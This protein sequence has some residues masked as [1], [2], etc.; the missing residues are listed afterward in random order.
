[1]NSS[2]VRAALDL[3]DAEPSKEFLSALR[4]R[5]LAE[6]SAAEVTTTIQPPS[7]A[8]SETAE[9]YVML[10]PNPN[11]RH[12]SRRV[13]IIVLAAA[14]CAVAAAAIVINNRPNNDSGTSGGLR[15]VDAK[16]ALSLGQAALITADMLNGGAATG[17]ARW[18]RV[19]DLTVSDYAEQSA[20]TSASLPGC[21]QLASVGLM[22]P[23]TKSVT[24]HQDF[25]NGPVPM[26]HD[27]WVFARP[28]DASRAMDVIAGNVYPTCWF[29]LFDRLTPLG[30]L[31][32]TTSISHATDMDVSIAQHGDRQIIITQRITYTTFQSGGNAVAI[33]AYV[34]VGRAIVFIDPQYLGDVGPNSN[35]EQAIAASTEALQKVFGP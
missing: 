31:S 26:L 8:A 16:E 14:A 19:D 34:Q 28:E 30:R 35:V 11:R 17:T 21:A 24:V 10:A 15:D 25:V 22:Q 3:V 29:D 20:A 1:V 7:A 27:V 18:A 5:L 32:H 4:S 6:G 12:P 33:N 23:T 2:P 9:E 13:Q